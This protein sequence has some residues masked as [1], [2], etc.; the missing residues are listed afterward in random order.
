MTVPTVAEGTLIDRAADA[1]Q[2]TL[3]DLAGPSGGILVIAPH[4]DDETLGC[5]A[6]MMTALSAGRTVAV[7]LL[8]DGEMSHPSSPSH[9]AA[10]LAARRR[11][12][13]SD[14]INTLGGEHRDRLFA[15]RFTLPDTQVPTDGPVASDA[16]DAL[17]ALACQIDVGAIWTTSR[18][19]PHCDHVAAATIADHIERRL[20]SL[21]RMPLRRDYAV[22]GRFGHHDPATLANHRIG[23]LDPAPFRARKEAAMACYAS[24][25]T[26][27]IGDDP[28]GFVMPQ[29]LVEHF[30]AHGEIFL[31][32]VG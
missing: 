25:L 8:T 6:A 3:A 4:P 26:P 18:L 1:P 13:F 17:V 14:A 31:D 29:P 12:E 7:A 5:G 9:P 32:A 23:V 15:H 21:G 30:A 20:R 16:V 11:G 10:V 22:W 24:Q 27:L 2:A 28:N 19:D